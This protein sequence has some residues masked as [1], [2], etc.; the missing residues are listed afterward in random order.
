MNKDIIELVKKMGTSPVIF[1]EEL[2]VRLN[3]HSWPIV[4]YGVSIH[5]NRVALYDG[6]NWH[7]LEETDIN[8]KIVSGSIYQRL[9]SL[10]TKVA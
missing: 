7:E 6:Y 10:Q 4:I 2:L 5:N 3:P 1:D 8:Y 9:K